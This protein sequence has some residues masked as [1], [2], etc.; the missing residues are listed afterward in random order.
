[1]VNDNAARR[2]QAWMVMVNS[3]LT[4]GRGYAVVK[5]VCEDEVTARRLASG[6][7][8]QGTNGRVSEV[9][10][11]W[12]DGQWWGPVTLVPP[13]REDRIRHEVLDVARAALAKATELGLTAEDIRAL[14]GLP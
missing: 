11:R 14:R 3:D 4:E 10:V 8:V 2:K 7:D 1:M 9:T 6:A 13:T 12:E 5:A